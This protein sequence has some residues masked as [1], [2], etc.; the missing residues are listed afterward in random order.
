MQSELLIRRIGRK[1]FNPGGHCSGV[2]MLRKNISLFFLLI[3]LATVSY[4]QGKQI[5]NEQHKFTLICPADVLL[6]DVGDTVLEFRGTKKKY[7][8]E[9]IFFL[10]NIKPV[11]ISPIEQL[12]SY[13]KEPSSVAKM[14]EDF[15]GSMQIGFPDIA[16]IDKGFVYFNER[17]A[18]Q[19]TYSFTREKT[20][21]KGRYMLVLVKEQSSIYVFS[22]TSKTNKYDAWNKTSENSVKSLKILPS[23][24]QTQSLSHAVHR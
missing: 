3:I 20:P 6:T 18:I 21:M 2:G 9:A 14:D 12:E 16:S 1:K 13:M 23:F 22:W 10:K 19:G 15:I 11:K 8:E 7:G 4:G 24:D 17:T 5:T